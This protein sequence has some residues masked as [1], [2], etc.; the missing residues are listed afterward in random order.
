MT[1]VVHSRLERVVF[2]VNLI[3]MIPVVKITFNDLYYT[4]TGDSSR[5]PR[6]SEGPVM[7]SPVTGT[8]PLF[9][10]LRCKIK[11][12]STSSSG[13]ERVEQVHG[14]EVPN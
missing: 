7:N 4:I 9:E 10:T 11:C 3:L 14:K 12:K 1:L 13:L 5:A 6:I 2:L 8:K